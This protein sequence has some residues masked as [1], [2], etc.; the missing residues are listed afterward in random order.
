MIPKPNFNSIAK[1]QNPVGLRYW[2][3]CLSVSQQ[4]Q[5]D[6]PDDLKKSVILTKNG[7]NNNNVVPWASSN[8]PVPSE[9]KAK[10]KF[11]I[12]VPNINKQ[13]TGVKRHESSTDWASI[14]AE[15][16]E[17]KRQVKSMA[18]ASTRSK[19]VIKYPWMKGQRSVQHQEM[20]EQ[21]GQTR[22]AARDK[23]NGGSSSRSSD[24]YQASPDPAPDHHD[25]RLS[26]KKLP[27]QDKND[28]SYQHIA[29]LHSSQLRH[30]FEYIPEEVRRGEMLQRCTDISDQKQYFR[31]EKRILIPNNLS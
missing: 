26:F 27:T 25:P 24:V 7:D 23:I 5:L 9:G 21:S 13:I 15:D 10:Q 1:A 14:L 22:K 4:Q 3:Q 12:R 8:T 28:L 31:T 2:N 17:H 29:T 18:P 16:E 6:I 19:P 20:P 30:C 11:L